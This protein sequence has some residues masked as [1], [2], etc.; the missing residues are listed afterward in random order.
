MAMTSMG[1]QLWELRRQLILAEDE[2]TSCGLQWDRRS[3]GYKN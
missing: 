2:H 3:G 1:P